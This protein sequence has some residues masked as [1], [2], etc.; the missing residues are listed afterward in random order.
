[1]KII[2]NR[3]KPVLS[4]LISNTQMTFQKGRCIQESVLLMNEV[5]HSFRSKDYEEK[6]FVLEADLFKAFDTLSWTFL[7]GVLNSFVFPSSLVD[8]IMICATSSKLSIKLNDLAGSG[9]IK[10]ERD[11]R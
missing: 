5:L 3:V 7:R 1:M 2:A 6:G 11:L 4:K 10:P 8:L 9:Y